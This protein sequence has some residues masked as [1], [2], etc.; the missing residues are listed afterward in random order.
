MTTS[1]PRIRPTSDLPIVANFD[2]AHLT[3]GAGV[4]I[5]HLATSRVVVCYHST[6]K[7]WFLP[8]GR[9]DAGEDSG[10]GAEREGF[11]ESGY[12]NRLLPIPL[13]HRQPRAHN[14][15]DATTPFYTEPV[16]TQ[17]MPVTRS[18]QYM[19]FWYI[20]ETLPPDVEQI[21]SQKS[22]QEDGVYLVPP[23]FPKNL[24]LA[25]RIDMDKK[26][27]PCRHE[28]TGVDE[29]EALYESYLLSV[30]EAQEKLRGTIM[31]DV[32]R[33]GWEA[34][35]ARMEMEESNTPMPALSS[36]DD[37]IANLKWNYQNVVSEKERFYWLIKDSETDIRNLREQLDEERS[38]SGEQ[39]KCLERK[40]EDL[41]QDLAKARAEGEAKEDSN[42]TLKTEKTTLQ[43]TN[44]SLEEKIDHLECSVKNLSR[45][46][47]DA[48]AKGKAIGKRNSD[49][50][51]EMNTL[52]QANSSLQG[53]RVESEERV[54]CLECKVEELSQNLAKARKEGEAKEETNSTL[55]TEKTTLQQTNSSLE[56]QR[57]KS[58]EKIDHLESKVEKL[59]Q[60]LADAHAK[61]K[62]NGKRI[63][64]FMTEMT[65]L[66]EANSSLEEQK[67]ELDGAFAATTIKCDGLTKE[68]T[69]STAQIGSLENTSSATR[70]ERDQALEEIKSL[71]TKNRKLTQKAESHNLEANKVEKEKTNLQKDVARLEADTTRLNA[72]IRNIKVHHKQDTDDLKE[73]LEKASKEL[74]QLKS[75]PK[76]NNNQPAKKG[77]EAENKRLQASLEQIEKEKNGL[78][79]AEEESLE[80]VKSLEEQLKKVKAD[81]EA[82]REKISKLVRAA[83]EQELRRKDEEGLLRSAIERKQ[84]DDWKTFYG[85][86]IQ[87]ERSKAGVELEK[88]K[89]ERDALAKKVEALTSGSPSGQVAN[90]SFNTSPTNPNQTDLQDLQNLLAK[91][92]NDYEA[93]LA[94]SKVL[95]KHQSVELNRLGS[96]LRNASGPQQPHPLPIHGAYPSRNEA[97]FIPHVG[98]PRPPGALSF[99]PPGAFSPG[100]NAAANY[101]QGSGFVP[102]TP[103]AVTGG[104]LSFSPGGLPPPHA[105]GGHTFPSF[106][107]PGHQGTPL[108]PATSPFITNGGTPGSGPYSHPHPNGGHQGTP[109][110]PGAQSF[111]PETQQRVPCP[112]ESSD[113]SVDNLHRQ[114]S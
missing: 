57:V 38:K 88:A 89:A 73:E 112:P 105:N 65:T 55:T 72:N 11:E 78:V 20:A 82:A 99:G 19:L 85:D 34:I 48:H 77:L 27:N 56:K 86:R 49:L 110:N 4:A 41:S 54:K 2:S 52:Q 91:R 47:A 66:Q 22:K 43:Q 67:R 24:T 92:T 95:V 29:D 32:V 16:W 111:T 80:M 107:L 63:S 62:A 14:S 114:M 60:D 7:Y 98:P 87:E 6:E 79:E 75:R 93:K 68:L 64:D 8:K 31:A 15:I 83:S 10:A 18:T 74:Q 35:Q 28:N 103:T 12:R 25:A 44:S 45:D 109:L 3:I 58:E 104:A 50:I 76:S 21:L 106:P 97:P 61:G 69:L 84:A 39:I 100:P 33:T 108:S 71:Q 94:D 37:A 9:R 46:L 42:S 81:E 23:P 90:S 17:L 1:G 13:R 113:T 101:R 70:L 40:V 53:K 59:T 30:D 102:R 96:L 5:F 51:S 36:L 26:S